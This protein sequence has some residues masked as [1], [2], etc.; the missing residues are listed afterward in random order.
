MGS[1]QMWMCKKTAEEHLG[2]LIPLSLL[3]R[4]TQTLSHS[5]STARSS[6][7]VTD[8]LPEL[9]LQT[10]QI[11]RQTQKVQDQGCCGH[12][13][14][15]RELLLFCH[16]VVKPRFSL[17][18]LVTFISVSAPLFI[19]AASSLTPTDTRVSKTPLRRGLIVLRTRLNLPPC[20]R[21][22]PG[23]EKFRASVP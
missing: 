10:S 1:A 3:M 4:Q 16:S 6:E 7:K 2:L 17:I 15:R 11:S 23:A 19:T 9:L 5:P 18:L 8:P 22:S 13:Q 12:G 20:P 14:P 21:S